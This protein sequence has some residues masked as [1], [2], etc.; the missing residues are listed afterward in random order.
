MTV[1][2]KRFFAE[3]FGIYP[4]DTNPLHAGMKRLI[5]LIF[6]RKILTPSSNFF[7]QATLVPTSETTR[8]RYFLDL[9]VAKKRPVMLVGGAG[10]GKTV[11]QQVSRD[12][13]IDTSND[14]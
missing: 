10:L 9:L 5:L 13:S 3:H 6:C 7:P 11:L 1:F 4:S 14:R 8:I 2:S 12:T